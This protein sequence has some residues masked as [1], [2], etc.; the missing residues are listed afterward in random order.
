M[1][2]DVVRS[3]LRPIDL[4]H[5]NQ[6]VIPTINIALRSVHKRAGIFIIGSVSNP[7]RLEYR[8]IDLDIAPVNPSEDAPIIGNALETAFTES[9][10]LVTIVEHIPVPSPRGGE[11]IPRIFTGVQARSWFW[12][13]PLPRFEG[14]IF[15]IH[16]AAS[17]ELPFS[18]RIL[19]EERERLSYCL[20]QE[21]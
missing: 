1:E 9:P 5:L 6:F 17:F 8:D 11:I 2:Q 12:G 3:R 19:D 4:R 20:W 7:T 10:D 18:E 14:A 16:C 15:E 13:I 21:P